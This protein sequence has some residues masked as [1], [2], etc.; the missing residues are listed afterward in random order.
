MRSAKQAEAISE[1]DDIEP[2][3]FIFLAKQGPVISGDDRYA[4]ADGCLSPKACPD[5][6][7]VLHAFGVQACRD[8]PL[9][10]DTL[11]KSEEWPGHPH[12]WPV[13]K[14]NSDFQWIG[15]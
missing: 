15:T 8:V 10:L 7:K 6:L 2:S 9:L 3:S 1:I 12:I 14:R 13:L 11:Q 5:S 4:I